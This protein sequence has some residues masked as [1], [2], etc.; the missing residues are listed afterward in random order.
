[1][2][3]PLVVI[4]GPTA[5]GKSKTAVSFAK[6][7]N[8]SVISCDSM[9]VYRYMDIGSA[10]ITAEEMQG[11]PHYLVDVLNPNEEFH[12]A[13]FCAMAKDALQEIY[14]DHR[15][16][17][18]VGGTGFYIR[19]LLYDVDFSLG[20]ENKKL[21]EELL[22]FAGEKGNHAL[23]ERLLKIDP[24]AAAEI[25]EN[26]VKRVIRA[27][28]FYETTGERISDH[29]ARQRQKESDYNFCF[30]VLSDDRAR[31]YEA[32][33]RRVDNMMEQGLL[34]EVRRL[35]DMGYTRDYVSMQ[36]LGYKELLDAMEG[37]C[38]VEEAVYRIKRD[39]RHFAK[40]QLTWFKAQKDVVWIDK[41]RF[42]YDEAAILSYMEEYCKQRNIL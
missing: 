18:L 37:T 35:Y 1:M 42:S 39:T 17:L 30:F 14:D 12:V 33:D 5:T 38:T 40:R 36:G 29:N 11:I 10:K 32:I 7:H 6:R 27:I 21:R 9:Q 26:N 4:A 16:P 41:V 13:R 34:D 20:D 2:K 3:K 15:L 22:A 31:M 24:K 8:G 23:H 28:E 19:A 25:H